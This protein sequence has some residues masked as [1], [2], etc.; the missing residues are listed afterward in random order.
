[1]TM[2]QS[3]SEQEA[4]GPTTI[5]IVPP[6]IPPAPTPN[7]TSATPGMNN[8]AWSRQQAVYVRH[9]FKTYGSS[10]NPNHVLQN[11]NMTVAKGSM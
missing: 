3:N 8:Q 10:S 4:P 6:N 1:M 9:V 2:Q 5:N 7:I 11:L